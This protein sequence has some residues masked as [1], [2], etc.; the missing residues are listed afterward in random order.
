MDPRSN[1]T[2][3]QK[4]SEWL[5]I[6]RLQKCLSSSSASASRTF[7]F[8]GHIHIV[9]IFLGQVSPFSSRGSRGTRWGR[10]AAAGTLGEPSPRRAGEPAA[11][12]CLLPRA[13]ELSSKKCSQNIKIQL[14]EEPRRVAEPICGGPLRLTVAR[15]QERGG[16]AWPRAARGQRARVRPGA[17]PSLGNRG[18]AAPE[19]AARQ[20]PP[21]PPRRPGSMLWRG[22][23][24]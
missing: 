22:A 21:P 8:H 17:A 23:A 14:G 12:T 7:A 18:P 15:G 19:P 4:G 9:G 20:P 13:C 11:G 3:L 24:A 16:S 5:V 1:S 2:S 10:G 6:L